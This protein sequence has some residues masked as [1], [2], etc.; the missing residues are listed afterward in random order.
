MY[1][2]SAVLLMELKYIFLNP[3]HAD[4]I[5]IQKPTMLGF[6]LVYRNN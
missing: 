3:Y 4:I 1:K 6:F 2:G 5:T